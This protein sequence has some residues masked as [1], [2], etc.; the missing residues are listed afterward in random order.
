MK[1][2]ILLFFLLGISFSQ[3]KSERQ[4]HIESLLLAPCCYGGIVSEHDSPLS[5]NISLLINRLIS[6]KFNLDEVK[7]QIESMINENHLSIE[8]KL[9]I[10]K[11]LHPNMTDETIVNLFVKLFGLHIRAL[12]SDTLI[13]KLAW[14]V[15]FIF[16]FISLIIVSVLIFQFNNKINKNN[17]LEDIS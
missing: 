5:N 15:P 17:K 2:N 12:P 16:L 7:P 13:G 4:I 9:D 3:F 14:I 10:I 11:V 6:D 1:Y 8:N